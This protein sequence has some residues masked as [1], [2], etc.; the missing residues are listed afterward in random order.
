MLLLLER[1][2]LVSVFG[3][4]AHV[5]LMSD[6][7][8]NESRRDIYKLSKSNKNNRIIRGLPIKEQQNRF[9]Y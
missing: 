8:S 2:K 9:A 5:D 4:T 6:F 1:K 7:A 3:E